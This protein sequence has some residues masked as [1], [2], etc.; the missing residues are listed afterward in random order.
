M[1][2]KKREPRRLTWQQFKSRYAREHPK[3]TRQSLK[4][5]NGEVSAAWRTYKDSRTSLVPTQ[6]KSP[7]KKSPPK[8]SPPR[9]PKK[10]PSPARTAGAL[11]R[12]PHH[13]KASPVFTPDASVSAYRHLAAQERHASFGPPP[14]RGEVTHENLFVPF[15][16]QAN[17]REG[18]RHT[19]ALDA[20]EEADLLR[21]LPLGRSKESATNYT[22]SMRQVKEG[23]DGVR[24]VLYLQLEYTYEKG[25]PSRV[26]EEALAALHAHVVRLASGRSI[27]FG[28]PY[29]N[30]PARS[31]QPP[32][33]RPRT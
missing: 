27:G 6:R 11:T 19:A 16:E 31:L 26:R 30:E 29:S 17:G 20:R 12:T 9:E 4:E 28:P 8:K 14:A 25:R 13:P 18:S 21:S 1:P 23:H 3:E 33:A 2:P 10:S 24:D 7:P 32:L 15:W 5:R 22:V